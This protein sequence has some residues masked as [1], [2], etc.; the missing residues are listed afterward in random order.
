MQVYVVDNQPAETMCLSVH[1]TTCNRMACK[2][3][4]KIAVTNRTWELTWSIGECVSHARHG[5][6]TCI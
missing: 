4:V 6:C 2:V 5:G 3:T 1:P